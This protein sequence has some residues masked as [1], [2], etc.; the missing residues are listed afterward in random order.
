MSNF[1]LNLFTENKHHF[2]LRATHVCVCA[3]ACM[4]VCMCLCVHACVYGNHWDI[5][6]I[7]NSFLGNHNTLFEMCFDDVFLKFS[8]YVCKTYA[9]LFYKL[10]SNFYIPVSFWNFY[11]YIYRSC[12]GSVLFERNCKNAIIVNLSLPQVLRCLSPLLF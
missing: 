5:E 10:N 3:C 1:Y 7:H 12:R 2:L 6:L 8:F 11:K 9:K 4:C